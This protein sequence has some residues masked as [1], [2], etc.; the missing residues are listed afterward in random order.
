[1]IALRA[2]LAVVLLLNGLAVPPV[3]A[4]HAATGMASH[5]GHAPDSAPAGS[6][7][8]ASHGEHADSVTGAGCCEVAACDCGC[9]APQA[10]TLPVSLPR[11]SWRT[12]LFR[13]TFIATPLYSSPRPAPF[14]PP[15]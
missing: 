11:A 8:D 10:M 1:V 15:A 14:R 4:A 6:S 7:P 3:G 13:S 12:A 5:A 2:L 9:A